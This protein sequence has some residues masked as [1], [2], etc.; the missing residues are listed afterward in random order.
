MQKFIKY[1]LFSAVITISLICLTAKYSYAFP[2][3]KG[4]NILFIGHSYIIHAARAYDE[5]ATH[6][7][8]KDKFSDHVYS[9]VFAGGAGG[10][11][12]ALWTNVEKRGQVINYLRSGEVEVLVM[13]AYTENSGQQDYQRWIDE[14]LK[15]NTK[16]E[17]L[18]STPWARNGASK[19]A[20]DFHRE[21]VK[22]GDRV[23]KIVQKLRK[24]NPKVKIHY[25]N[26][27]IVASFAKLQFKK[28]KLQKSVSGEC[29]GNSFVFQDTH[30]HGGN[31]IDNTAGALF[32][33]YLSGRTPN[34]IGKN[35]NIYDD[36]D[37]KEVKDILKL[38][39]KH[40]KK[41]RYL[42]K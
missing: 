8:H 18:I 10:S 15:H 28:G 39:Y 42:I 41:K 32:I 12:G 14:A 3:K 30:G 6:P 38:T 37:L 24:S 33:T 9:E 31:I 2:Y 16:T 23:F 22:N 13:T 36:L 19:S 25:L 27:G 35:A 40:H 7:K 21:N 26:H 11:P 5:I 34:Q 1:L 4:S 29:C 17:F 20:L